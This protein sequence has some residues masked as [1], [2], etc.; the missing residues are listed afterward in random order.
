MAFTLPICTNISRKMFLNSGLRLNVSKS[1][2]NR[3]KS[4]ENVLNLLN[5][6]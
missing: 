1:Q 5:K 6:N 2:K 4:E 3:Y